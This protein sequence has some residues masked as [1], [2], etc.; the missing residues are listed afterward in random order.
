M[1]PFDEF[2]VPV[3]GRAEM[4]CRVSGACGQLNDK[5]V[6]AATKIDTSIICSPTRLG[7]AACMSDF[8]MSVWN[9]FFDLVLDFVLA[10][11]KVSE[12]KL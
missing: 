1:L 2:R 7:P 11:S 4:R 3:D 5:L 9:N 6:W 8:D 10:Y 12:R